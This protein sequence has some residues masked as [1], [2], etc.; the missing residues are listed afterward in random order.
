MR[1]L[2]AYLTPK[3]FFG[4][5]QIPPF[6]PSYHSIDSTA[7]LLC[8]SLFATYN[9]KSLRV[10]VLLTVTSVE[11]TTRRLR[12]FVQMVISG[13]KA[14]AM[15]AEF[16]SMS[17]AFS[18]H[19]RG[20]SSLIDAR[21]HTP[22]FLKPAVGSVYWFKLLSDLC[23]RTLSLRGGRCRERRPTPRLRHCPNLESLW[24]PPE[25]AD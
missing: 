2:G 8:H 20:P 11:F 10:L 15:E 19:G 13:Q 7:K 17:R 12:L 25:S 16:S 22:T 18:E 4:R 9:T 21:G 1:Y 3:R 23:G 5:R 24:N 14:S 6:V